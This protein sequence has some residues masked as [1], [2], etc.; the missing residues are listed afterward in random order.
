MPGL[1][2]GIPFGTQCA[3]LSEMAGT[4]P[5]HDATIMVAALGMTDGPSFRSNA[6]PRL[7]VLAL[8]AGVIMLAL[9]AWSLVPAV[10]AVRDPRGDPFELIPAFWASATALPLG[11]ITLWS[12]LRGGEQRL[13]RARTA[14]IVAAV[15]CAIVAALEIVRRMSETEVG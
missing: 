6:W 14:L 4:K 15:L 5:G 12:G 8:V 10:A 13:R 2:P 7:R 9:W 1:D 3:T 11:L